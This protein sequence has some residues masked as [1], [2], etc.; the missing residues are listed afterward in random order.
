MSELD[1]I[2]T[3]MAEGWP[4]ADALEERA[5]ELAPRIKELESALSELVAA[6]NDCT[7]TIDTELRMA[8]YGRMQAAAISARQILEREKPNG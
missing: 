8:G 5:R 4:F 1:H 2:N 6:T 7:Y 3:L